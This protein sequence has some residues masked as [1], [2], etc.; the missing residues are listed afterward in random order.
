MNQQGQTFKKFSKRLNN[1]YH[2]FQVS[3]RI[4]ELDQSINLG[5]FIFEIVF[6]GGFF[7]LNRVES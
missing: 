2:C 4:V 1:I 6:N 5:D 7:P 3:K